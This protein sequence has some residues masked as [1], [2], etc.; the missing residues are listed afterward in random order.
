ML[1]PVLLQIIAEPDGTALENVIFDFLESFGIRYLF[2]PGYSH[3][4]LHAAI[5]KAI[6]EV[7]AY[8][9]RFA[10]FGKFLPIAHQ[11]TDNLP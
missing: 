4:L 10:F 7:I 9:I 3:H 1:C 11:D 5:F 2:D 8:S 6:I